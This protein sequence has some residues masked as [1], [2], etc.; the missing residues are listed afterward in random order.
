ML[1][2]PCPAAAL[3]I[4]GRWAAAEAA[5]AEVVAVG[6]PAVAAVHAEPPAAAAAAV[7][8]LVVVAVA[9]VGWQPAAA[10]GGSAGAGAAAA[11]E[12]VAAVAVD[13]RPENWPPQDSSWARVP[14]RGGE[15]EF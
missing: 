2:G 4:P 1:A 9:A 8:L 5:G 13:R 11:A 15:A 10:A 12:A 3:L 6:M 14:A 7:A